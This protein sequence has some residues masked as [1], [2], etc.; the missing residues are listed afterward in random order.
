MGRKKTDSIRPT[1][2][3]HPTSEEVERARK[4]RV[5]YL[6]AR[7]KQNIKAEKRTRI[8]RPRKMAQQTEE[9]TEVVKKLSCSEVFVEIPTSADGRVAIM[10]LKSDNF[11]DFV[12]QREWK[13][14]IR[15]CEGELMFKITETFKKL[16][17]EKVIGNFNVT[18]LFTAENKEDGFGEGGIPIHKVRK[19]EIGKYVNE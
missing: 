10:D 4:M 16:A 1:Y 9:E 14:R 17:S 6:E 13:G 18:R 19:Q 2:L 12:Y 8:A 3:G 5:R 15:V 7:A 11:W